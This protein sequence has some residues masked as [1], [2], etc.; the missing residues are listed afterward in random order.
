MMSRG[1]GDANVEVTSSKTSPPPPTTTVSAADDEQE[2]QDEQKIIHELL[3]RLEAPEVSCRSVDST[4]MTPWSHH[5]I[6]MA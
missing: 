1:A 2:P 6:L 5:L 4:G 3:S